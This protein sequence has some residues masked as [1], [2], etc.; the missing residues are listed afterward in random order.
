MNLKHFLLFAAAVASA[1]FAS[2]E[3][4]V[5][6]ETFDNIGDWV[7]SFND[8]TRIVEAEAGGLKALS[9]A[10]KA[11]GQARRGFF[12]IQESPTSKD[13]TFAFQFRFGGGAISHDFNLE[14][15]FGDRAKPEVRTIRIADAGACFG[16]GPLPKPADGAEG[17]LPSGLWNTTA[18]T[19]EGGHAKLHLRR[20]GILSVA[21]EG[22]LPKAP[23]VGWNLSMAD[24]RLP[25]A[26]PDA[27][28]GSV[29][30]SLVRVTDGA[31]RPFP[32]GDPDEWLSEIV[33]SGPATMPEDFGAPLT[34]KVARPSEFGNLGGDFSFAIL[35]DESTEIPPVRRT[36]AINFI[37]GTNKPCRIQF[38]A[39]NETVEIARRRFCAASGLFSNVTDKVVLTNNYLSVGGDG[40]LSRTRVETRPPLRRRYRYLQPQI[41]QI[42]AA[43]D[44]LPKLSAHLFNL[45]A[46]KT[47]DSVYTLWLDGNVI[48][49][50]T[51]A[52]PITAI[53]ADFSPEFASVRM[54]ESP[55]SM[56]L[57]SPD[58]TA[59]RIYELPFDKWPNG[60]KLSRVRENQGT[61]ALECN[62][63]LQRGAFDAMP[64]SCL[65]AVPNR[66]Y[67]R[68]KALCRVDDKA[69]ADF[70]PE[71]TARLTQFFANGGRSEAMAQKTIR[72]PAPGE[73]GPLPEG[74]VRKDKNLYEVTFDLDVGYIMDMNFM[75]DGMAREL[76]PYLHFEFTGVLWD[77][78]RYYV[79]KG[80]SPSATRQSSVVILSG[81]LEE[82]PAI[83]KVKTNL[84]FGLY[85]PDEHPGAMV[86]VTPVEPGPYT[87]ETVVR[88][89]AGKVVQK[90]SFKTSKPI[91]R[92]VRFTCRDYG[93]YYV[94]LTLRDAAGTRLVGHE[95]AY[96]NIPPNTRKAG[97][98]SLYYCWNFRGAHGTPSKL[99]EWGEA[100]KRIGIKRTL[101][102]ND[103]LAETNAWVK[104][105][106]FTQAQFPY[107]GIRAPLGSPAEA[108]EIAKK[109]AEFRHK[110]EI[111]PHCK[112]ALLFHESGGGPY[113]KELYGGKTEVT[114]ELRTAD[115]NRVAV[116]TRYA[117]AWR[118]ADPS[119]R[120]IV[121]NSGSSEGL[122]AQLLRG[123]FPRE[124]IDS[125]GEESV[126]MTHPPEISTAL[127]P[128]CLK[129]IA[130]I[131]GY[132][133]IP[134]DCPYEW[135]SRARRYFQ[136]RDQYAE[137]CQRDMLIAHALRYTMIPVSAG[138]PAANS[139][140]DTI[141][142][143]GQPFTRWPLAYPTPLAA[144]NATHTLLLD[145]VNFKRVFPTGSL[146]AY[147]LEF[148]KD[149]GWIYA[150]WTARGEAQVA[151]DFGGNP[152]Y[153]L[154]GMCGERTEKCNLPTVTAGEAPK[155]ILSD[156]PLVGFTAAHSRTFPHEKYAGS[157]KAVVAVDASDSAKCI[158]ETAQ[159]KR[160][161]LPIDNLPRRPG[162]FALRTVQDEGQGSCIELDHLSAT[163]CP[164]L[165]TEYA[166]IRF[167]EAKPAEGR[168][169]TIGALVK[170]NSSWGT[171][172]FEFKDAEGEVWLSV[173]SGGY[174]C[175]SY[176]WPC[177][178]SL[179]FDGW[180][181]VQF[182]ITDESPVKIHSPGDNQRQWVRDCETG[183]GKVDYP[184]TV[185]GLCVGA[186][187]KSLNLLEMEPVTEQVRLKA[188]MVY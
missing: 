7:A 16:D 105:Y 18:L 2:A 57:Y 11:P 94:D 152:R 125:L 120:L 30:V 186:R 147:C 169:T 67:W 175:L 19:V 115:S 135:K 183:N 151:L 132:G 113:P 4:T 184:I 182:P 28:C 139:Y 90:D 112:T 106:G 49:K 141:W 154:V 87:V 172:F 174:G 85:Y 52:E 179:N 61:Y 12:H 72:L 6:L 64:S 34:N 144:A 82:S 111:F 170:G 24:R 51:A 75:N 59:R 81:S 129:E 109:V 173:G 92:E 176:D 42:F 148:E 69:P 68:A 155:Y 46:R 27:P 166:W 136:R 58:Y 180:H 50:F 40:V 101:L 77:N 66:Q 119:V 23:L 84:P 56:P 14:L 165:M 10:P 114:P 70:V 83:F 86:D 150:F 45:V 131:Y 130:R 126:G 99:S 168:P 22:D 100:Y 60:F 143:T 185:T 78:N 103:S 149:G 161:E 98:D 38:S 181:F 17:L 43:Y 116:A 44:K 13:W 20:G 33:V 153:T 88:D 1:C 31:A 118:E 73:D 187:A 104:A 145:G 93:H 138:C 121:G 47:S 62:G 65:F 127:S 71:V 5:Y 163:N 3:R 157:D 15:F 158:L 21:C 164:A 36:L 124:Y 146:T 55:V 162:N 178:A 134:A 63:Y 122:I 95:V 102:N 188:I 171:L 123:G 91:S 25:S 54:K 97:Y 35:F 159:D 110:C 96:A 53:R 156:K 8:G 29:S 160:I 167:P 117:K 26:A 142:G 107:G 32:I 39:Q 76:L 37:S 79:D 128:W 140:Y 133:E 80:R 108:K 48:G 89:D 41:S 137:Y 9:F 177:Q 74:V